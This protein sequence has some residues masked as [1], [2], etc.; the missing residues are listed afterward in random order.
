MFFLAPQ[1]Q[2]T[3]ADEPGGICELQWRRKANI[4]ILT[5]LQES[6]ETW[7]VPKNDETPGR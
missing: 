7:Q 6:M 3:E 1:A 5:P 4:Q 2:G